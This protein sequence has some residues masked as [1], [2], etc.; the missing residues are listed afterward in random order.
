MPGE[1]KA[2]WIKRGKRGVMEPVQ[3]GILMKHQGLLHNAEQGGKRQVT[4][5]SEERWCQ[6]MDEFTTDL[7]PSARRANLMV[8]GIDLSHSKG[9]RLNIGP[10]V[11]EIQGETK[12]CAR[13]DDALPGLKDAMKINWGGGAYGIVVT[14]G[15]IRLGHLVQWS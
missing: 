1:L 7:D 9:K 10:A 8:T 14:G 15:D 2:I 13:M 12:P 3:L 4:I 11:I 5:I 6:L